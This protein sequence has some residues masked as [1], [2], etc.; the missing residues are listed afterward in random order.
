MEH[1]SR[2]ALQINLN[3]NID[4]SPRQIV[5]WKN[6]H[7]APHIISMRLATGI[8]SADNATNVLR[9]QH[10]VR[11]TE[12]IETQRLYQFDILLRIV[13]G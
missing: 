7:F 8:I 9:P 12:L 2:K 4:R 3:S 6:I 13:V 10:C 5:V 1:G 11:E